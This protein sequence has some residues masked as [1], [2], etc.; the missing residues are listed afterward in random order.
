MNGDVDD[1]RDIPERQDCQAIQGIHYKSI[2]ATAVPFSAVCNKRAIQ[3]PVQR[4]FRAPG[5][6]HCSGARA[7]GSYVSFF[8]G[9]KIISCHTKQH[10]ERD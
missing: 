4:V 6:G 10:A 7:S 1:K 5:F 8:K 2:S 9:I 3:S